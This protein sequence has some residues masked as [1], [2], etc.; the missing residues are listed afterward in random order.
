MGKD[1]NRFIRRKIGFRAKLVTSSVRNTSTG[2][3]GK[4]N[5]NYL[6]LNNIQFYLSK[7]YWQSKINGIVFDNQNP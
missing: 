1:F 3:F 7:S 5:R 6:D 2:L 4:L